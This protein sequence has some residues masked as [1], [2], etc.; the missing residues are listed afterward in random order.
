MKSLS[1]ASLC[2]LAL[3]GSA[4]ARPERHPS[5]E[6]DGRPYGKGTAVSGQA[7]L[8]LNASATANGT[9]ANCKPQLAVDGQS[10]DANNHWACENLPAWH[11][12]DLGQA[13]TL[14]QIRV[15]P[16][17]AD[18]RI[19]Q[20]NVEGSLDGKTWFVLADQRANSICAGEAGF[21]LDVDNRPVRYVRTTFTR[22]SVGNQRGG[23]L[24]EIEG[25]ATKRNQSSVGVGDL[26]QRYD[27]DLP[28][29]TPLTNRLLL[30]GWRGE[31]VNAIVVA[32]SASGFD[33]IT[34]APHPYLKADFLRYTL[35][36][37]VLYADIVDGLSQTTFKG[38]T[39]PILI[40]WQVPHRRM[41]KSVPPLVISINGKRHSI[42]VSLTAEQEVLPPV[43]DWAMHLDVWQHPDPIARWHDVEMWSEDH[44]MFL[45]RYSK[46]LANLGQKVITTTLIDEAWNSQTY[47]TFSSMVK[48]TRKK[49]GT[50]SYDYAIFDRYVKMMMDCGVKDQISCYTM[51]P[52]S[53]T[54]AY[55]DEAQNRVVKARME[56]SSKEYQ[57]FWGSLLKDFRSHL[58]SKGWLSITKIA[59]DERPD[60]LVRPVLDLLKRVAPEFGFVAA[61]DHPSQLNSAFEDVSYTFNISDSIAKV[62]NQRRAEKKKTTFYVCVYPQRPNT[63]M[64][65]DPAEAAWLG[66]MAARANFDGILRWAYCSWVKNPLVSQDFTSWPSGDTSLVYPG[67][68]LSMR[69]VHLRNGIEAYE[70]VRILKAKNRFTPEMQKALD[71]FTVKRGGQK[72]IH[73]QDVKAVGL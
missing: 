11:Q 48:V 38:V 52:W 31:T 36:D 49:N 40:T 65:S 21:L 42:P 2:A 41:A 32:S 39:R 63:F 6:P 15:V 54:F 30:K 47:D 7:N 4:L 9:W 33:E 19:Y 23:H 13:K 61:C 60:Y 66:P 1:Y 14:S 58:R 18:G 37:G 44:W 50:W 62:I 69:M 57:A 73:A 3:C 34:V 22:N 53:L 43:K 17:W 45:E 29:S 8:F 56:P 68:R 27:R 59:I 64:W 72:G 26:Y 12:L 51:I 20:F 70:K 25:F 71:V 16:Y 24:V 28:V 35:G 55:F 46:L 5:Y 67:P 10:K